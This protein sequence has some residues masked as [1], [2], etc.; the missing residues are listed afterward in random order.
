MLT[1]PVAYTVLSLG[2]SIVW[3][4]HSGFGEGPTENPAQHETAHVTWPLATG[5]ERVGASI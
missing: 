2:K 1:R 4:L 5:M 3:G